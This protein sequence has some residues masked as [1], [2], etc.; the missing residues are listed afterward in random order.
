EAERLGSLGCY[1]QVSF[2]SAT[3]ADSL[4]AASCLYMSMLPTDSFRGTRLRASEAKQNEQIGQGNQPCGS[5]LRKAGQNTMG[6]PYIK[7]R[8]PCPEARLLLPVLAWHLGP[9]ANA[10][11]VPACR[12]H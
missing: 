3:A 4:A 11:R 7:D 5:K 12:V 1:V 8:T 6:T 2:M 9:F 10:R